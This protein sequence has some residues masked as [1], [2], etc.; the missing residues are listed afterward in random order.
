MPR[1]Q[2]VI[3]PI[4]LFG[5]TAYL[6]I[7]WTD[8]SAL[9]PFFILTQSRRQ[10]P[11]R[12]GPS[13]V[14]FPRSR[15]GVGSRDETISASVQSFERER[16][17][18]LASP[19][20]LFHDLSSLRQRQDDVRAVV[21]AKVGKLLDA[22]IGFLVEH[23]R[24]GAGPVSGDRIGAGIDR[25]ESKSGERTVDRARAVAGRIIIKETGTPG[26]AVAGKD[27]MQTEIRDNSGYD[28]AV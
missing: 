15:R 5:R 28:H 2:G 7:Y 1:G 24:G 21:A 11:R 19:E 14:F 26:I 25:G 23:Q 27:E 20:G 9:K 8:R 16:P 18:G 12:Q 17:S 10:P 22:S 4:F 13:G 3:H 6:R